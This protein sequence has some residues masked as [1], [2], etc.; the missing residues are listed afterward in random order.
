VPNVDGAL[1]G[2]SSWD[3]ESFKQMIKITK[4]NS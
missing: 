4:D 3:V 2:T 1:I